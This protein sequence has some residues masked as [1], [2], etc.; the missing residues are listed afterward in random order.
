V[1]ARRDLL[2]RLLSPDVLEA[3]DEYVREIVDEQLREERARQPRR[4]W[5]PVEEGAPEYGCTEAALRARARRGSVDS[6]KRGGRV[7][8]RP[9]GADDDGGGIR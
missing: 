1:S 3:I 9:P 8:V 5:L 2:E 7:Y 6:I 4:E